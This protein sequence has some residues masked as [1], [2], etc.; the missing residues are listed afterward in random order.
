MLVYFLPRLLKTLK[1]L[2]PKVKSFYSGSWG[3]DSFGGYNYG[4]A[5]HK[6]LT[7]K[8]PHGDEDQLP[9]GFDNTDL[10]NGIGNS[11]YPYLSHLV[12]KNN[13]C[14]TLLDTRIKSIAKD[15]P[16]LKGSPA[17]PSPAARSGPYPRHPSP[18]GSYQP[19]GR[20]SYGQ[21]NRGMHSGGTQTQSPHLDGSLHGTP[22][23]SDSY[24]TR[25]SGSRSVSQQ[26]QQAPSPSPERHQS[27]QPIR[28]NPE[29]PIRADHN[30][31]GSDQY[32]PSERISD[33]QVG[34]TAT[35]GGVVGAAGLVGGGAAVYFLNVG[36]IRTLI[37]G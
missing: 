21:Y 14:L 2:E 12:G 7:N 20:N 24:I 16:S 30:S 18:R 35:I 10:Y 11:L 23:G 32:K 6:W 34:S 9:G 4:T 33:Y 31:N 37:A 26:R 25:G 29:P 13:G 17:H 36:G 28:G 27:S 1:V 22:T 3:G 19:S 15:Y 8:T 5:I